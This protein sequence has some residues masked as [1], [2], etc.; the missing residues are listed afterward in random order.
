M[1]IRPPSSRDRLWPRTLLLAPLFALA[2]P[3]LAAGSA[4]PPSPNVTVNLINRLVERNLLSAADAADLIR[5]A[6]ADATAAQAQAAAA[7]TEAIKVAV[8]Q[9]LAAQPA[10]PMT[11]SISAPAPEGTVRVTYV[12]EI[13]KTQIRDQL[14]AEVLAQA[15]AEHWADPRS[16]PDWVTRFTLN[17]DMRVRSEGVFYPSGNDTTGAFPNFNAIN[18]GAPFDTS[19]NV[20]SPQLNVNQSRERE[21]LRARLGAAVDLGDGFTSGFRLATGNDNS[22]ISENQTLGGANAAQGGNFAKYAIWLDRGFIRYDS[23]EDDL[24]YSGS[25]GRFDN[26]F[27]ATSV[28]WA[29]DLAFDGLVGQA[30]VKATD[31]MTPF[32][33]AGVFPVFNTELNFASTQPAKFK[34]TD[35]WLYAAQL[36]TEWKAD[37]DTNL[38]VALAYYDFADVAGK[39]SNPFTPLTS[40][41]QGNTDDTRPAF[42][43]NGNTYMALR[44]ITSSPLNNNGT[45]DQFQYFGLATP[46]R[47][48][49]LT[50]RLDF[51]RYA[52]TQIS[53]LGEF[54]K[55][56]AF[57]RPAIAAKAVNNLGPGGAGD[58]VGGDTAWI[59]G[60]KVGRL[61]LEKRGDWNATLNYR[62]VESD[63]VVDGFC[64]SDFGGGGTNLEGFT[65][66]GSVALSPRVWLSL[67]WMSADS[68]AGPQLRNDL[69]QFDL[70]AKF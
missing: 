53:F 28:I 14:K 21:R 6:G 42:A 41:D 23:G 63:S 35:K 48:L 44:N 36:G 27:F 26:P 16:V 38:K 43:Q 20:F 18:T 60:V 69:V 54:I 33:T 57:R 12:P 15:K 19:G 67:R 10:P 70:N 11:A 59:L 51:N 56:V 45:I 1:N 52:P 47:D 40:S 55:N 22:P 5:Q 9:A 4:A 13:V 17:G 24:K 32:F 64:D 2:L 46:F 62:H 50:A 3:A 68:I 30:K 8:A 39:L 25:V 66:G 7:Q 29:D 65:L 61:A 34:S 37:Q 31:S 49:A 58:Y